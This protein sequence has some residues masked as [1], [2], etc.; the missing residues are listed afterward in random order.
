MAYYY[1]E[2]GNLTK[3]K[4]KDKDKD[5]SKSKQSSSTKSSGY[6]YDD[7]GN[8]TKRSQPKKVDSDVAPVKKTTGG[9]FGTKKNNSEAKKPTWVDKGAFE[10]GYQFGDLSKSVVGTLHDVNEN[11]TTAV[12]DATE[13]LIDTT[14]YGVGAVGGL[15]NK[16][17]KEDVG[18]FIAKEILKPKETGEAIATYGNPIGWANLLV[19]DGKTEKNSVLGDKA[20][21]LVQS[22]AHLV[23]SAALQAVG[24]PAWLT[25]GVNAF[26][27]EIESAFQNDAT[28]GEAGVSGAV[29]AVSEIVFEKLSG[30]IKFK[31][32]ALD[33]GLQK[34][35]A[36]NIKKKVGRTVAKYTT[37]MLGEGLEE[38]LTEFTSSIGK[39]LTYMDDK[40]FNEIMSSE[41][42]LDAFIGGALISGIAGGGQMIS[43][44]NKG[45]DYTSGLTDSEEKV[46]MKVYEDTIAEKEKGGSKL[47]VSEKNKLYDSIVEQ[48]SHGQLDIDTIEST[49]GGDAYKAYQDNIASEEA[50]K[51][52]L[53]E[54]RQMEYGKMNDI[55]R[56]RLAEL[57]AMNLEDTTKREGLRK[58]LNDT[59][60]PLIDNSRLAESYNEIARR[61]EAFTADLSQYKGKQKEAVDRAIKSGVLNNT[62]RSHELVNILS[63]IEADKG[64]TFDYTNNAKLKESGFAVEGKTVNG[65]VKDGGVTLNVQSSK[66]WQSTVGHEITHVLENTEAYGELQQALFKYAESKGELASRK[67]TLTELYKD[68]DADIDAELTADLVGEYLFTDKDFVNHLTGNRTLFQKIYDE[69]KYLCKVATGKELTEIEKVK[70]EFDRAWKEYGNKAEQDAESNELGDSDVKYSIREEAPPKETGVAYKVF[71]VKDGKLYPPMVANPDGADTP[72]GVWLNADVGVSAPPSKTGRAQVKAGG[73]GTQGGSGSLAFRPGWH[74][75]DLP[76]ASQFDRVNPETGKKELFPENFVWAEVE[77]AKDVDYQ[78]E[79]MSYGYTENGKFRHAYAGLPKLPENGYYRYRTNPKPDTV[80]WVIT[81]AMKVNRLLSDAE[82]NEILEKNGVPAVHRQGGDVGLDKFGFDEGGKVKYSVSEDSNG[83]ELRLAVQK[84]FANSKAV[85]ENGNLKVLYHGTYNGEFY[86]F[87]KSKGNVEGDFGSGFYFTDNASDV[88]NNYEG[89]GA[90]FESKVAIRAEQIEAE[91]EI[92]YHEAEKRARDEL[93]KGD[94]KHTVYLNIENPAIVGETNLFDYESYAEQLDRNDYD[95]EDDYESDVEQLISDDIER[96]IWEVEKNVDIYYDGAYGLADVLW[97]AVN[98]GGI[99]IEQLKAKINEL[100]FVDNDGNMVGNE[101]T[102]QIIESL[103]YDGIIDNTVSTKFNMDLEEGTTHY[104][105]FKPNQ[106]KSIDNQNPTDNPDIRYSISEDTDAP[107]SALER[108]MN[109]MSLHDLFLDV[110][111]ASL[112]I[113]EIERDIRLFGHEDDKNLERRLSAAKEKYVEYGEFLLANHERFSLKELY[114]LGHAL[115][116]TSGFAMPKS[117]TLE[118]FEKDLKARIDEYNQALD[119]TFVDNLNDEDKKLYSTFKLLADFFGESATENEQNDTDAEEDGWFF[120]DS[121][122]PFSISKEGEEFA[123]TGNF[124]TP[125]KELALEQDI[126]PATDT[127]VPTNDVAEDIAPMSEETVD[128]NPLPTNATSEEIIK[129]I[130]DRLS[131]K[132]ANSTKQLEET[133]LLRDWV[134]ES[135]AHKIEKLQ[136]TYDSKKNKDT[137][138]AVGIQRR[139]SNLQRVAA[140]L[141]ADLA[142]RI[143]DIE[144]RVSKTTERLQDPQKKDI[145]EIRY[146]RINKHLEAD[147]ASLKEAFDNRRAELERNLADKS[148]YFSNKAHVLYNEVKGMKKGVR[149]SEELG[150]L[151]D[152][153]DLS[154]ENK[155]ASYNSLRTA[156]LNIKNRPN[157]TVNQNSEIESIAR[158]M[159]SASYENDAYDLADMDNQY[160]AE[161]EK[162][163]ADAQKQRDAAREE[164]SA[165]RRGDVRNAKIAEIESTLSSKGFNLD[166]MLDNPVRQLSTLETVDTMPQRVMEKTFGYEAGQ[167]L[168]DATVNKVALNES[169]GIKWLDS[170]TNRKGGLL[171]QLSKQYNIK[172]GSKEIQAAQM[173]AEGSWVNEETDEEFAYG[174][175]ELAKDFPDV[176]TQNNIKALVRDPRIRQF[177]DETL[178]KINEARKRN[179][180]PEIPK[181]NNYYLHYREMGDFFT[182]NGLPF[183]PN[184]MRAKDLPTD[185]VGRTADLKPGQ[186]YFTSSMQRKGKKTSYNLFEG[187]ERYANSAK[188]QIFHLDDIQTLRALH[189]HLAERFGQAQ[190]LENLNSLTPEQASERIKQVYGSHLSTFA[191]FLDTEANIL[192]GKTSMIDRAFSE[193]ILGRRI[194]TFMDALN[195]Q[196]GAAMVGYNVSSANTNWL[197]VVREFANANPVDSVK[198]LAQT[199]AN[200]TTRGK[201]DSFR[202]DSSV[203][204]RRQGADRFNR[205]LWQKLQDPAYALMGA[206]DSISTEIIARTEYNKA[207]RNGMSEQEAHFEA[208]KKTSRLMADRSLG[209]MPQM[210]TS[211]IMGLVTKFQ[212]E[213]RNDLDS[214]FYDT[215]QEEKLSHKDI[216][217]NLERNAKTAAKVAWRYGATA[218]ALHMFGQAFESIAGYNPAFDIIEAISKAF[219]WDDEEDDED[220]WRDNLGEGA[221]SLIEDLPYASIFLDGG[222]IP[223]ASALPDFKGIITGKDE[224]GNEKTLGDSFLEI[225]PYMLPAGGNQIK[226]TYQ[227]LKMFSDEHPVAGSYTDSGNLRFP[228]EDTPLNR[229]QAGIFGQYASENARDYFDNDYA[230]LKEKQI[231]EYIDVDIPIN[232]YWDYREGLKEQDTLEEKFD[233]VAGLDLPV[234]KKNILINNIVDRKE[235]VDLEGYEDFAGYEEFD[236]AIKNPEKWD[237]M[238]TNNI[239]YDEYNASEE[240]RKAYNWAYNNPEGYALSKVVT[241]DVVTYRQYTKDLYDIK[242]D[243]DATGKSISGSRKTKVLN[244]INNMSADYYTKII[245]FKTEYPSD[246]TYNGEIIE[247]INGRTDISDNEKLAIYTELGFRVANGYVYWD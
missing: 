182:K 38:V 77:Y 90:D 227:G 224:Y 65:F 34:W 247:Y 245:L 85:D 84:R 241:D 107:L 143:S 144:S 43:A 5:Q 199:V 2:N 212:L 17:F 140:D 207:I 103:G 23:G 105:V 86:T 215:L 178:D 64:I 18:D 81:G 78:E 80:P 214:M 167:A 126:A 186:P 158:E 30:G 156:L 206:V 154:A 110:A 221:M 68:M 108:N 104:I 171:A 127:N 10:D 139:I 25:M 229:V 204:I 96:I 53:N 100:F 205:K 124:S 173:Y 188:N 42:A 152:N 246:D 72:M 73:K 46:V 181:R 142:K 60:F 202:E 115:N 98:E 150:Y 33:D 26:G 121:D 95:S 218:V 45:V 135:Y 55:Q 29:S 193:G 138:V 174:D 239:S 180:Y 16:G 234:E 157:S 92:E 37:G 159:L 74:L 133:K 82:V 40:E 228:V 130:K 208:D 131:A 8:L 112:E 44:K 132:V 197:P 238:Q 9:S 244:Y 209:Q 192:A 116:I 232:D 70:R 101:V 109:T 52:E 89:G 62:Y 6:Y 216:E 27:G 59:V 129:T 219:G 41:D 179:G 222:R 19:N 99:G 223:V 231:Q 39:K 13:N 226:K 195:Q 165:L 11:L 1:D 134:R 201:L 169:E 91:E 189:Y 63:K 147:K 187:M 57:K 28:Y 211:R 97:G 203:Y 170:I 21:G 185:M 61:K 148:T 118:Q 51:T 225:A 20:D 122:L 175:A 71:F 141:D 194:L 183:N 102:R 242:A 196:T 233:Y 236:F 243:K 176:K 198:A 114:H 87:D 49:L 162:L 151:L 166:S 230:P 217:N 137:K 155:A 119:K 240:S 47:S 4:K 76:R 7:S 235:D 163:E 191:A 213:L 66:A 128:E 117:Y 125:M 220:T 94:F 83:N 153:L 93:Y 56:E 145:L 15:F 3:K 31:G 161:V 88:E 168:A 184:D 136:A 146:E 12:V 79:A 190:G 120:D 123:P 237:F 200:I 113:E 172:P 24:V 22:G 32:V 14:A 67:A 36:T 50:L 54:L 111:R 210:Y 58:Q 48:M 35:L 164:E 149:V 160:Q 69:I 75:G 106:I 177:Y